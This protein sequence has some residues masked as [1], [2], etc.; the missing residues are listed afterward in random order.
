MEF[1][2]LV[3]IGFFAAAIIGLIFVMR[4]RVLLGRVFPTLRAKLTNQPALPDSEDLYQQA[5]TTLIE[6]G[7]EGPI[8][9]EIFNEPSDMQ[10]FSHFA[11]FRHRELGTLC[12][13][14]PMFKAATPNRLLN[15]WT[16]K[17]V[18]GR[19]I[20]SQAFDYYFEAISSEHYPAQSIDD[21]DLQSQL[22]QHLRFIQSFNSEIDPSSLDDVAIEY[23]AGEELNQQREMLIANGFLYRNKNNIVRGGLRFAIRAFLL[24]IK[25]PI[26]ASTEKMSNTPVARL[27]K[28]ADSIDKVRQIEPELKI[29]VV[30]FAISLLLSC[31]LG[32]MIF[33]LEFAVILVAVILFHELGHYIAMRMFGYKNVHMLALPLVG[34]VTIGYDENPTEAKNAWMSLMGPLP[35]I[36]LGWLLLWM[37]FNYGLDS[38]LLQTSILLL[39]SINYLNVLPIVPLDGGRVLQS[40]IPAKWIKVQPGII[41]I[42]CVIGIVFSIHMQLYI[43][44]ILFALQLPRLTAQFRIASLINGISGSDLLPNS[45]SRSDRRKRILELLQRKSGPALNASQRL[46]EA[47]ILLDALYRGE[48]SILQRL[49][50]SLVYA[51]LLF[52]PV[53]ILIF[54][55][56]SGFTGDRFE[57]EF[58]IN[59]SQRSKLTKSVKTITLHQLVSDFDSST[60][61]IAASDSE[62]EETQARLQK[63]LP[64]DLVSLYK[65]SN[66]YPTIRHWLESSWVNQ[67]LLNFYEQRQQAGITKEMVLSENTGIEDL[68]SEFSQPNLLQRW[69]LNFPDWPS[70]VSQQDIQNSEYR[71]SQSLPQSLKALYRLHDA[72]PPLNLYPLDEIG[73]VS[74]NDISQM[75]TTSS[76]HFQ[77]FDAN[78]D[79]Q[80]IQLS[81]SSLGTCY[82]IAG[83]RPNKSETNAP[84]ITTLYWCPN[85]ENHLLHWIDTTSETVYSDFSEY[86]RHKVAQITWQKE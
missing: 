65:I 47:E 55:L 7:F 68:L 20:T 29:Q 74:S 48:L 38:K 4:L 28:I 76:D 53:L 50:L 34:G 40:L 84:N 58:Q 15:Y 8:W 23:Q 14:A 57:T 82:A 59:S 17:L 80:S 30:I 60:P 2:F 72:F 83:Y 11:V 81:S 56:Q 77:Y 6:M 71:L 62:I 73:V 61:V 25:R 69:L 66:A 24:S 46:G 39:L 45:F 75:I 54:W 85:S 12:W 35:G 78:Y 22:K 63:K 18:D 42:V 51:L 36:T 64:E 86:F 70:G 31:V 41:F 26:K 43:L 10:L 3:Q 27:V 9:L 33:S 1:T 13:L 49:V 32:A 5:T 44:A 16:T 52:I 37:S 19:V 67:K 21:D 79:W